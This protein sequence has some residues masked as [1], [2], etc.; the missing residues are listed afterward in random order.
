MIILSMSFWKTWAHWLSAKYQPSRAVRR[1][2]RNVNR[3]RPWRACTTA[4][5]MIAATALA[6]A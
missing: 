3:S 6:P 4:I 5:E 2:R 1:D